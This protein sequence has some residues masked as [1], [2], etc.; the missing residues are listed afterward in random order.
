M[1]GSGSVGGEGGEWMRGLGLGFTNPV[2]TRGVFD[3]CLDFG[4]VSGVCGEWVWGLDQGLE[5]WGD[6][7]SMCVVS[8]DSLCRWQASVYCTH[9]RCIM[10]QSCCTLWIYAS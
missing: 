9:Q 10:S 3:V 2:K 8:L 1:F 4:G 7:M 6:V 5:G